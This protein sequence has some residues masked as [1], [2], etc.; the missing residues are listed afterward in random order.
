MLVQQLHQKFINLNHTI[1]EKGTKVKVNLK[2]EDAKKLGISTA[3][4]IVGEGVIDGQYTNSVAGHYVLFGSK[5]YGIP[6]RL[7]A[8]TPVIEKVAEKEAA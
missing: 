1:M 2:C 8:I 4:D 7:N 3:E 6:D 5:L